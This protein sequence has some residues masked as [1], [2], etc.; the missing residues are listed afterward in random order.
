MVMCSPDPA[1]P[2]A[3]ERILVGQFAGRNCPGYDDHGLRIQEWFGGPLLLM[4]GDTNLPRLVGPS[5][6]QC[7]I[8]TDSSL[9]RVVG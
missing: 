1:R 4:L 7:G 3:T 2:G 8:I 9:S 5:N 6:S